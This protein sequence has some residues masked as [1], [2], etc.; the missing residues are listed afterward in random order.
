MTVLTGLLL[1]MGFVLIQ[2]AVRRKD[3][4]KYAITQTVIEKN[5]LNEYM[6]EKVVLSTEAGKDIRIFPV[7]Y[8]HLDVYKRQLLYAGAEAD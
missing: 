1:I 7:S 8:T 5:R 4:K 3:R 2:K 6:M